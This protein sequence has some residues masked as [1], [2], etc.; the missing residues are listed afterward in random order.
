M[1]S[2]SFDVPAAM[3]HVYDQLQGMGFRA[4][5]EPAPAEW[6]HPQTGE[7]V[8]FA[9]VAGWCQAWYH[10]NGKRQSA[11]WDFRRNKSTCTVEEFK[12]W[13]DDIIATIKRDRCALTS[14]SSTS[15]L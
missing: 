9:H 14:S 6:D 1:R 3:Q 11:A 13:L 15:S 12:T 5:I 8:R 2:A 7:Y 4:R 10:P